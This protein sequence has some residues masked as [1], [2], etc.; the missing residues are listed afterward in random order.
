MTPLQLQ[1]FQQLCT[2]QMAYAGP[3]SLLAQVMEGFLWVARRG[4]WDVGVAGPAAR[5]HDACLG[6]AGMPVTGCDAS[7]ATFLRITP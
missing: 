3:H 6:G 4:W 1:V 7:S 2:R 5:R